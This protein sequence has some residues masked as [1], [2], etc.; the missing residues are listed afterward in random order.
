[1][2]NVFSENYDQSKLTGTSLPM[3]CIHDNKTLTGC[4]GAPSFCMDLLLSGLGMF[5]QKTT[6]ALLGGQGV[7]RV[8]FVL[9]FPFDCTGVCVVFYPLKRGVTNMA[10][11]TTRV[12]MVRSTV[13]LMEPPRRVSTSLA[14][15]RTPGPPCVNP[16]TW[17]RYATPLRRPSSVYLWTRSPTLMS[18]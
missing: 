13:R 5:G 10:V 9:R 15:L 4:V 1:M 6:L 3:F 8:D 2:K 16:D 14:A 7:G 18:V 12:E 17:T 11:I